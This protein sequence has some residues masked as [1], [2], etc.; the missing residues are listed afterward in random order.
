MPGL[1]G[2]GIADL[3]LKGTLRSIGGATRGGIDID[4]D[5][6]FSLHR[7]KGCHLEKGDE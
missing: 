6:E 7:Q 4:S 2:V 3:E 5:A 1:V